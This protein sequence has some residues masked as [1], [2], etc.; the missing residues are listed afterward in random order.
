MTLVQ[1]E[2]NSPEEWA[3]LPRLPLR[4]IHIKIYIIKK[5]SSKI[6][7]TQV[8]PHHSYKAKV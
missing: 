8:S 3:G 7:I 4:A 1:G 5:L 6:V 2:L